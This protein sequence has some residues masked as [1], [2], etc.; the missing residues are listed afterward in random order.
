MDD[1]GPTASI[2]LF[3]ILLC[4]DI[5]FYGFGSAIHEL[6]SKGIERKL[7]DEKDKKAERLKAIMTNP[8]NYVDTLQLTVT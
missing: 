3:F 5:F 2:I 1:G 6:G 7:E 8:T 4:M